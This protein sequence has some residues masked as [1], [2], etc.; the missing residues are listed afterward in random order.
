M[1][2]NRDKRVWMQKISINGRE[3]GSIEM[4][5]TKAA[6]RVYESVTKAFASRRPIKITLLFSPSKLRA[7]SYYQKGGSRQ[8]LEDLELYIELG[9]ILRFNTE[10]ALKL[11]NSIELTNDIAHN[12]FN[13]AKR[14][15]LVNKEKRSSA[16]DTYLF[17]DI[18]NFS[19]I[20]PIFNDLID[21]Y[22]IPDHHIYIAANPDSLYLFKDEWEAN[23]YD[24]GKTL[25]SFNFTKCDHGKNVA[26]G[27][28]LDNFK[29]LHLRNADVYVMTFDR[30]LKGL[31]IDSCDRSNNLFMME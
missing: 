18:E 25:K 15:T 7:L 8:E 13:I 4:P 6:L 24:Y 9:K 28:L 21:K 31:F 29:Q 26:D 14:L 27:V 12:H 30:E 17:W 10:D 3:Y 23:L 1:A 22:E 11:K 19:N 16:T 2:A 5:Q 20:G